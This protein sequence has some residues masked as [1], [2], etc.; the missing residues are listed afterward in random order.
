[1]IVMA[2]A[3][4]PYQ[5]GALDALEVYWETG[6]GNPLVA[7]ATA[8]GKSLVIAW[9]IRDVLRQYPDLCILVLTHV[10]E[11]IEQ[12]LEHLLALWPDA[13]VGVNSAALGR[14][15]CSQQII[16]ASIQS[17]F[18]D[19]ESLGVRNLVIVDEA[20][21][22]PHVGDGMYRSL[23]E[24]LRVLDPDMRVA[25]F[26]ATP[27]RLDSG[28]L[29]EGDGKVFDDVV[30]SYDI[31]QGIKDGWLSPLSSKATRTSI[32]V[33]NVGRRGG[34]FIEHELQDAADTEAIVAG[35]ADEIVR[36]GADRECWLVFCTGVRHAERVRDALRARGVRTEMVLGETEQLERERIIR[37]F[38]AGAVRC[39]VNV[40]VLTTGFN[41]PQ[42]DLIAMLR[43][44][45]STGLYV[46]ML[47]R[48]SRRA[49]G[50]TDC[51]VLDF[52]QNV[53]R[54]GP[55]DCIDV[56]TRVAV[57][58]GDERCRACPECDELNPI[59]VYVCVSCGY[60]WPRPQPKPKHATTADAVPVLSG[61]TT[62]VPVDHIS[63]H[64]HHKR[65]DPFAPPSLRVEYLCG[66]SAY[67]EYLSFQ[68]QGWPR[69][70]AERW[71]FAMGGSAPAPRLV[72]DALARTS[73]LGRVTEISV[74]RDGRWWRVAERRLE[75]GTE[76]DQHYQAWA[77][78]SRQAA[79]DT[80][81]RT[82]Y[83]DSVPY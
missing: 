41:V 76:I 77:P 16:F 82:P 69:T 24:V 28:R 66:L 7:L 65:S 21:L 42:V 70:L 62:C 34:E 11:L 56:K 2:F 15:D 67:E 80:M 59:G 72:S 32:D 33:S 71:W 46:Q 78:G 75:S 74:Y 38:K 5:R 13:P 51:L 6:G 47:G 45:L 40:M 63:F 35:A 4:R 23:I 29:D 25:G 36:L 48:G 44:T 55:V 3:L 8:T 26:T 64:I 37:E 52:A 54:H 83:N 30:F 50:K 14:R 79:Y 61:Q 53:W 9:L 81:R 17:V 10:Q 20:H 12:N 31:G 58:P 68:R 73:E 1:V 27:F 19:P 39:V 18:R 43:P 22:I 57:Q 60:E 49:P